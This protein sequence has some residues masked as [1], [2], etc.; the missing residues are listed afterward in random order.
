VASY[1]G[2][3]PF[4]LTKNH[5]S[6]PRNSDIANICFLRQLIEKIG[7]GTIKMIEDCE[8]KGYPTPVWQSNSGATILTFKGIPKIGK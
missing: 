5:L 8:S 6:V 4:A 3:T 1:G 2:Y 7:R